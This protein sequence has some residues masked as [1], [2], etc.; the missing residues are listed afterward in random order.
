MFQ[1]IF[2]IGREI[3]IVEVTDTRRYLYDSILS[4]TEET[5]GAPTLVV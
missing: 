3:K 2:V 4:Y 1:N 5:I